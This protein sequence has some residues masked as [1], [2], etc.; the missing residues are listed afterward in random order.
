MSYDHL[1]VLKAALRKKPQAISSVHEIIYRGAKGCEIKRYY[2]VT[3]HEEIVSVDASEIYDQEFPD[4]GVDEEPPSQDDSSRYM[5][6][7]LDTLH[8]IQQAFLGNPEHYVGSVLS[9]GMAA[10]IAVALQEYWSKP[11]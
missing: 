10:D 7:N 3:F 8:V 6:I 9:N 5:P 11:R 4:P 2:E 1:G